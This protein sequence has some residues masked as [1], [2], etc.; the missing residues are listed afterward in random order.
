MFSHEKLKQILEKML[1]IRTYEEEI[2]KLAREQKSPGICPQSGQEACAIGVV[3]A[4]NPSDI[5]ITN[6]RNAGHLLARGAD[7]GKMFAEVLGK[8]TGYCKGKSGTLHISVKDLNVYLTSTIVGGEL[9]FVSGVGL[10]LSLLEPGRI[11]AC[12][13]GDGAACEGTFHESLNLASVWKL[14][15]LYFCENNQWQ[16]FVPR[17]EVMS[18]DYISERAKGYGIPGKTVD[19]NDVSAVYEAAKEAIE[20][21]RAGNGPYLLEGYT[22]RLKGHYEPDDQSYVPK[23]ELES[24]MKKDPI[25][26]LKMQLL[27]EKVLTEAEYQEIVNRVNQKIKFALEF[28]F[29]SPYP[30]PQELT[31]DVY[32]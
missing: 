18:I 10:S 26:R 19:G 20:W 22:Y 29:N 27:Q 16:A 13:F 2:L 4:L 17:K 24:W 6:H 8:A 12:F 25:L 15:I 30:N 23:D 32:A 31:T 1:L 28:A 11:V 14:P 3:E 7:P 9:S 21:I 5:V